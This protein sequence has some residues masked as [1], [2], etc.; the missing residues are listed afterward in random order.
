MT[1][2]VQDPHRLSLKTWTEEDSEHTDVS[3]S[4]YTH[5][6]TLSVRYSAHYDFMC[7]IVFCFSF[8]SLGCFYLLNGKVF[9][10]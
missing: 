8:L 9:S 10:W 2:T 1:N 6:H 7:D 5:T 3:L 4:R